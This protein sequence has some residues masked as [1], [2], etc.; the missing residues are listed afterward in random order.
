MKH[1]NLS[2]FQFCVQIAAG[3]GVCTFGDSASARGRMQSCQFKNLD[4]GS[5]SAVTF[6]ILPL[7]L[8]LHTINFTLL[9]P[10]NS[11]IV[12]KTLRVVVR[13]KKTSMFF[14][15]SE[16][17]IGFSRVNVEILVYFNIIAQCPW[18]RWVLCSG[19][20]NG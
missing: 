10:R 20:M 13:K 6:R 16:F 3:D 8:G 2:T 18:I 11:E 15:S 12:V 19:K 9:T 14:S 17:Q 1:E 5:S 7:E 4:A